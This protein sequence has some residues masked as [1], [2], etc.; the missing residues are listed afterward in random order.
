MQFHKR[1]VNSQNDCIQTGHNAWNSP[2]G[3]APVNKGGSVSFQTPHRAD[4]TTDDIDTLSPNNDA[5]QFRFETQH[6]SLQLFVC[7]AHRSPSVCA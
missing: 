5:A 3:N 7:L 4:A 2:S 1:C 6:N